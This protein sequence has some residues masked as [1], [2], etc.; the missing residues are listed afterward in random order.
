[1]GGWWGGQKGERRGT[2]FPRCEREEQVTCRG[3]KSSGL[4]TSR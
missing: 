1:M 2:F 4:K 3:I